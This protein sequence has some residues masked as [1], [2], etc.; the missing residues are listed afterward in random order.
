MADSSRQAGRAGTISTAS[1]CT[2]ALP[3]TLHTVSKRARFF[4]A[5]SSITFTGVTTVSPI[6]TGALKFKV[7]EM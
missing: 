6:L 7:C 1:P 5:M 3:L 4:S 2:T